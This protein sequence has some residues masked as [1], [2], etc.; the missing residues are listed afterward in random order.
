MFSRDRKTI[1]SDFSLKCAEDRIGVLGN[2]GAGKSTLLRMLNGL[3]LPQSGEINVLGIDVPRNVRKAMQTVG[4]V[5][6]NADHQIIFPTVI[7]EM[8]FGL[9]NRGM[10]RSESIEIAHEWLA[11]HGCQSWADLSVDELSEGQRQ[12]L[13]LMS[14]SALEPAV[15]ALDEPFASLD[16]ENRL[17]LSDLLSEFPQRL[18]VASHDLELLRRME[19][20]IWLQDGEIV[21]D[22]DPNYVITDYIKACSKKTS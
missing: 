8:S 4:F 16:L 11:K 5:F 2:N 12:K 21:A 9:Q 20:V 13:C 14:V 6:Q 10:S 17:I 19:R 1:F 18:I 15:I 3:L 22:G 7:D